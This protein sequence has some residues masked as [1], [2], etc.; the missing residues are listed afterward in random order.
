MKANA[1]KSTR[2]TFNT[3]NSSY[4]PTGNT[5]QHSDPTREMGQIPRSPPGP[6]ATVEG[7]YSEEEET[8]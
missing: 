7:T 5:E 6:S 3:R 1:T 8:T 2:V 4:M